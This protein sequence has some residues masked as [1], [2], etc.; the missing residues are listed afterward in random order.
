MTKQTNRDGNGGGS[1]QK[2]DIPDRVTE[3]LTSRIRAITAP[4]DKP[5]AHL[6]INELTDAQLMKAWTLHSQK[7]PT[8]QIAEMCI[9]DWGRCLKYEKK[10]VAAAFRK[11]FKRLTT[12]N[13]VASVELSLT[14]KRVAAEQ[15]RVKEAKANLMAIQQDIEKHFNPLREMATLALILKER[16]IE[17]RAEEKAGI[18]QFSN[19]NERFESASEKYRQVIKEAANIADLM[20]LYKGER[21]ENLGVKELHLHLSQQI[22][23]PPAIKAVSQN[24]LAELKSLATTKI[25]T[26]GQLIPIEAQGAIDANEPPIDITPIES[27]TATGS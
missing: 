26:D 5:G 3:V 2:K 20:G 10:Q 18:P 23:N 21:E 24:F 14:R 9:V 27:R 13:D 17:M 7:R 19:W 11:L 4:P 6:C 1:P 8:E 25:T 16:L 15:E 22:T 12:F